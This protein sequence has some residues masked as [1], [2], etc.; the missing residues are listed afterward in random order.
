MNDRITHASTF[1]GIGASEIAAEMLGW[2]NLFHCEI[3]KFC[4]EVLDY[5]FPNAASYGDITKTDFSEWRGKVTVLTGGFPCQPFSYAGKRKGTE[6]NRYLWPYMLRCIEQIRPTWVVGENVAGIATMAFPSKDVKVGEQADLFGEG[7]GYEIYEKREK[8]VLGEIYG[9]LESI[10][11]SVQAFV[12]PACAVGAPHRRDR[13]FIVAHRNECQTAANS[14]GFRQSASIDKSRWQRKKMDGKCKNVAFSKPC[15]FSDPKSFANSNCSG[16]RKIHKYLQSKFSNGAKFVCDGRKWTV[17]NTKSKQSNRFEFE[18]PKP[19]QSKPCQSGRKNCKMY[20]NSQQF[21]NRWRNF[22]SI[23]PVCGGDDGLPFRVDGLSI[24]FNKWRRETLKAYG[25][26]IVPQ[27]M[28]E[29]FRCIDKIEKAN[30]Q[31]KK[32]I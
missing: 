8:Y 7:D 17:A 5:H 3:N 24:S 12:I 4:R 23:P 11:Y 27:L 32:Q 30:T 2:E 29:I 26:A 20:D 1:S 19:C 21:K 15:R 25:N 13:V 14:N 16:R 22:P 28:Y 9:N 18:Q 31:Q 10:G 6:D